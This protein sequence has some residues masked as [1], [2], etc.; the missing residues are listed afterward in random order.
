MGAVCAKIFPYQFSSFILVSKKQ[1]KSLQVP[2]K[3]EKVEQTSLHFGQR[4]R[5]ERLRRNLTQEDL[6]EAL[7]NSPKSIS[8]WERCLAI[9]KAAGR[10]QLCRFFDLS[11]EALFG[12]Q[13][14]P[15]PLTQVWNV[16]Y[17]R[18]P[19]FTGQQGILDRLYTCLQQ[20]RT[21]AL[22]QSWAV[23]G[24]GGIGKT[25]IA[26]E[27]VYRYRQDYRFVFWSSAATQESLL[28]DLMT[29]AE[30]LHLPMRKEADQQQ[31]I[32]AVRHWFASHEGWLWVLDNADDLS[33]VR[34][35][36]P[37]ERPGHLLLTTR[38]HALGVLAQRIEVETM[39]MAEATM[40]LLR[41]ARLIAPDVL[42]DGLSD[43]QLAVA[44]AIAI[45]LDFLPLALEQAGAYIE[46]VGC[47]LASY[48]DLYSTHRKELLARRGNDVTS[49][50]YSVATTW[51]LSFQQVGLANPAAAD[52]L[53]LCAFL[54]PD[55]IPEELIVAGAAHWPSPLQDA[56]GDLFAFQKMLEELTRFSL[57]KRVADKHLIS[58]HRLV[59]AVQ[60]ERMAP[61]EQRTWA[62][63]VVRAVNAVFPQD[64]RTEVNQ[65]PQCL[66]Y[67]EQAQASDT[68]IQHY[69][70]L[71]SEAADLLSRTSIYLSEQ[72]SYA[73]AEPL[74]QRA[75]AIYEQT[76]GPLHSDTTNCLNSLALL[77]KEEGRYEQ[78]EALYQRALAIHER[79]LEPLHP[80]RAGPL[81]NLAALYKLQG[82]YEQ[83]EALYQQ[84]LALREQAFGPHH[85]KTAYSL[86]NLAELYRMQKK[87]EQAEPLSQRALAICK[88]QLGESHPDT[89]SNL[90]N[91]ALLYQE[92]ERYEQAEPLYQRALAMR[93]QI[94]GAQHPIVA[95]SL[96][97][98]AD[99]Y[100][101]QGKYEQA[102]PLYQRALGICEQQLGSQHLHTANPLHGLATL[103]RDQGKSKRAE[104]LF[105]RAL[106]IRER[107]LVPT[108][109][110]LTSTLC[111]F[112]LLRHMQGRK[113]EAH[114]LYKRV[115][116]AHGQTGS[117]LSLYTTVMREHLAARLRVLLEPEKAER[118]DKAA[119]GF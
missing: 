62:E 82:K 41:R 29:I 14:E 49:Y 12:E 104:Q 97:N 25:Q 33:I 26:L 3:A 89:A 74:L 99:L 38:A 105:L 110:D 55:R 78:A 116:E 69:Q 24:L 18:N 113:D 93:E 72:A 95:Q 68:L 52:L 28:A 83:A 7:G 65:W 53:R 58:I 6:A 64:P 50:S 40:L 4:L 118:F 106:A 71:L 21:T 101:F 94:L 17:P 8:R 67:L 84:A 51:S 109:P 1:R 2:G 115:L 57:V 85:V 48:L 59:Q 75:L 102:E 31:I 36:I 90:N 73:L 92:Q 19:F 20:E 100:W 11:L 81:N 61:D 87:Y 107:E 63:R 34:D 42:L 91:L 45:A 98:L 23:S 37:M 13:K 54:A 10:L 56:A 114:A 70:L 76:S 111:E 27:Y 88:Q 117:S 80:L 119:K 32:A 16:P 77:Y 96:H 5:Q 43:N 35:I 112:A 44:E 66:L 86:G 30:R 103:Y 15:S 79:I 9:P 108:H 22:T 46:E 60:I 47:D 39:G